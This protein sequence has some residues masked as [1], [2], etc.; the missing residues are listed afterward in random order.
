M[1]HQ[2]PFSLIMLRR[3]SVRIDADQTDVVLTDADQIVADQ[4][5]VVQIVADQIVAV[6][7]DAAQPQ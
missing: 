5:D 2:I 4:S 6:L 3:L 1:S 7:T